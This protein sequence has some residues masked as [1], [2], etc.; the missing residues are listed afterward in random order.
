MKRFLVAFILVAFAVAD[1]AVYGQGS[2][3]PAPH[4][5]ALVELFTSEGCSSCPPADAFLRKINGLRTP[6]GVLIV[7]LSEHVTYWDHGGWK[8]PYSAQVYTDR[9]ESYRNRFHLDSAYTPQAVI[10]GTQQANGADGKAILAAIES[11]A[12]QTGLALHIVSATV[13][14]DKI[15]L[16][17]SV[18]DASEAAGGARFGIF[19]V[20]AAD[21]DGDKVS[22]GENA[23]HVLAHAAVA[24]SIDHIANVQGAVEEKTALIPLRK[25][26]EGLPSLQLVLFAQRTGAGPVLSVVA[27]PLK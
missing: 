16:H 6:S 8:D 10:D 3:S 15:D 14:N 1:D 5:I 18:T 13:A 17:Y 22:A 7:G 9:Q 25:D 20:V 27:V 11:T 24:R 19:A 23:G 21:A 26:V 2:Q 12:P 4:R